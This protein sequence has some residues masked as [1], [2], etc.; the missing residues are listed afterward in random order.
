MIRRLRSTLSWAT[1]ATAVVCAGAAAVAYGSEDLAE[2]S[3][4]PGR[5]DI[6]GTET[7]QYS[8]GLEELI[9]RDFFQDRRGG[10]Y[11]DVGCWHPIKSSNTYYLEAHL[12]WTGI[13]VDGLP[14][15]G[16]K[17]RRQRRGS[18]FFNYLVTDHSDSL[19][20]FYREA[21]HTDI[22]G[23]DKREKAPDGSQT[24]MEELRIPSI[25]LDR[26]LDDNGV[27][28]LDLVSMD[29]EG[30]ELRALAG[31]DIERFAP[32][33]VCVEAKPQNRQG[34]LDY[35]AEHGYQRIDRY[36]EHDEMNWYFTP[37]T[38]EK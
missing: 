12:D 1:L 24:Q 18:R 8:S 21:T 37:A 2:Q 15:M 4:E 29:I 27:T 35:F 13:G 30:G 20:S 3:S 11:L 19:T 23:A 9:I 26:L 25:T 33:L 31:F 34:L 7:K 16:R 22:S 6:L 10:F 28:S 5:K 38:A 36:L 32:K 14:E 17:W